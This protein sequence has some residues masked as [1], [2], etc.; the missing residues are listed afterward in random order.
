MARVL[1]PV[2]PRRYNHN[3]RG[4]STVQVQMRGDNPFERPTML[5]NSNRRMLPGMGGL[6][7]TLDTTPIQQAAAQT[8]DQAASGGG[9]SW[10]GLLSKVTGAA[11]DVGTAYATNRIQTLYGPKPAP[12]PVPQTTLL[13]GQ[14][15]AP[16][17]YPAA[18]SKMPMI[19]G[20][21]AV[22]GVGAFMFLRK[23]KR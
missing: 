15:G 11:V 20:V 14:P 9:F 4:S 2:V 16:A 21:A 3:P 12:L 1:I 10:S 5:V 13:P 23:K 6:G 7:T 22:V 17:A 18:P 8:V 19:L